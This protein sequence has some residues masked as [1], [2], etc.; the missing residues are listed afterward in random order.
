M[1]LHGDGPRVIAG[2]WQEIRPPAAPRRTRRDQKSN[3]FVS[4]I[5]NERSIGLPV[6]VSRLSL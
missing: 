6:V 1:G 2:M 4:L 3:M 5:V